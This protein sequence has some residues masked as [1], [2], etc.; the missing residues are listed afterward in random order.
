[1]LP[2]NPQHPQSISPFD[3]IKESDPAG[4]PYWKARRLQ[5]MLGYASWQG[6]LEAITRAMTACET[7]RVP[8]AE[9]FI[10][11]TEMVSIGSGAQRSVDDFN[12]SRFACYLI[13]QNGD[14]AKPVIAAAQVY[15]SIQ[16][17][18]QELADQDTKDRERA[19]L[20]E[21]TKAG[22]KALSS[23]AQDAGVRQFAIFHNAGYRGLYTMDRDRVMEKK[24]INPKENPLDRM[25]PSELA[26]HQ[27]KVTQTRD[28]LVRDK[29]RGESAATKAHH[30]VGR[31]VREAI[32]KIG[33][34]MPEDLPAEE[35][36]KNVHKRLK[37]ASQNRK[38]LGDGPSKSVEAGGEPTP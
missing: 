34:T 38:A 25:G 15:F 30:D 29:I 19:K 17:R 24:G 16:S 18:R 8:V 22:Y 9:H 21:D 26:A 14:P 10:P 4:I 27:F 23:A 32:E 35:P 2:D 28:M 13:A 31:K 33:G 37:K 36:I 11:T 20:R 12:L 3:R 5:G 1:M 6:F 7:A